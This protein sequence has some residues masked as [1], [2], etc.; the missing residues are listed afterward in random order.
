MNSNIIEGNWNQ[1][2]GALKQQW[3][4]LTDSDIDDL[5]GKGQ[6]MYGILQEKLGIKKD[7]LKKDFDG[8]YERFTQSLKGESDK[9]R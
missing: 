5:K 2:K 7:E 8:V 1:F 3:S 4:K 6:E 9:N